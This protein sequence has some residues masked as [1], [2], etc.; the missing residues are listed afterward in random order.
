MQSTLYVLQQ[1][2][3]KACSAHQS[4][5]GGWMKVSGTDPEPGQT[6][7]PSPHPHAPGIGLLSLDPLVPLVAWGPCC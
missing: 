6:A 2:L 5:V 3:W 7:G 4:V 1:G